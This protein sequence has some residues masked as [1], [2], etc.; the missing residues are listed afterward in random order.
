MKG[1]NCS[2]LFGSHG[3]LNKSFTKIHD[4]NGFF[5]PVTS[6]PSRLVPFILVSADAHIVR[7]WLP[8]SCAEASADFLFVLV[9]RT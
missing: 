3:G 8:P 7:I 4:L 2:S 6:F 9:E 1:L 5:R